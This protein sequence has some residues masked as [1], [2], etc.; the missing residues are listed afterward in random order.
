MKSTVSFRALSISL[1]FALITSYVLCIA[2]DLVFGWIMYQAWAPL[3]PGF[4]WPLTAGGFVIGLVWL[5]VY[6][7][8]FAALIALPY[9]YLIRQQGLA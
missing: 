5:V 7:I 4:T 8:Y 9:N 2:A 3:L 6:S 1:L